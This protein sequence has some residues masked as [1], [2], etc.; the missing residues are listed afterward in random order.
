MK[1]IL[2]F[3][4]TLL[5]FKLSVAQDSGINLHLPKIGDED[6]STL[7]LSLL[8]S[9]SALVIG[10]IL[11]GDDNYTTHTYVNGK[12]QKG[13]KPFLEQTPRQFA[14]LTGVAF[15]IT[16]LYITIDDLKFRIRK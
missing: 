14:L 15:G 11:E 12:Y 13:T 5:T 4:F 6:R 3:I 1:K 8:V 9:G 10:S 2:I 16:G 7:G